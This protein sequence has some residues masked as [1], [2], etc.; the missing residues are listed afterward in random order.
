VVPYV[1]ISYSQDSE[2]HIHRILTIAQWFRTHGIEAFVDK[3][4][5]SP[6]QSWQLWCYEQITKASYVLVVCTETYERRVLRQETKGTGRGATW[7]GAIITGEIY[8]ETEGQTKFIP[9][10]FADDDARYIPFFLKGSSLYNLSDQDSLIDLYRRITDQPEYV[11]AAL[12]EVMEFPQARL[13]TPVA[14]IPAPAHTPY[15]T[16]ATPTPAPTQGPT[17][18]A[19]VIEGAWVIQIQTALGMMVMRIALQKDAAGLQT[20]Q[21]VG[22]VGPPGWS[23]FGNWEIL[24]GEQLVLQGTQSVTV[25]FP[26]SQ[27]YQ[28]G[29]QFFSITQNEMHSMSSAR[30]ALVWRRE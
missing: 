16:Q 13:E 9:V 7:E 4:E 18:L 30:E 29:N 27:P 11:P 2:E 19:D 14:V 12:G 24:P 23:A 21:A 15:E 28:A 10:V 17:S 25:P 5:Q 1:F 3:F 22:V 6:P 20:F 26:Q 8:D